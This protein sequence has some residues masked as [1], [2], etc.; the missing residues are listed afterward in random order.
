[1][2]MEGCALMALAQKEIGRRPGRDRPVR[3]A[4][5]GDR[6][7]AAA[8]SKGSADRH[9]PTSKP[10]RSTFLAAFAREQ[11]LAV[12]STKAA[13][14]GSA[15][16]KT[17]R[18]NATSSSV[19]MSTPFPMAAISTAWR[20]GC[21]RGSPAWCGHDR[22]ASVF[23]H[24]RSRACHARRGKPLVLDP[25]ISGPKILTGTLEESE[26]QSPHKGDGRPMAEHMADIGLPVE[27]IERGEP[28]AT[29]RR[30]PPISRSISSRGR[31]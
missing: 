17:A 19:R 1:M 25:A 12:W 7:P 21:W 20:G 8:T 6:P 30:W 23:A 9:S 2:F 10:S 3:R 24:A 26:L 16:R 5:R 11:G 22:P 28:L 18:Q 4:V 31:C 15:C 29:C 14:P 13:M 27:R